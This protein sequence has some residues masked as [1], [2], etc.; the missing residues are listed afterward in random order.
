VLVPS[1]LFVVQKE[2]CLGG[3]CVEV[4]SGWRKTTSHKEI[5]TLCLVLS[6]LCR[7]L[8]TAFLLC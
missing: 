2:Y 6:V 5:G 7:W 8:S 4:V 1:H 3:W